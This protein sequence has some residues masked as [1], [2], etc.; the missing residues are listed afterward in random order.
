MALTVVGGRLDGARRSA[1]PV[2]MAKLTEKQEKF[3]QAVGIEGLSQSDAYRRSYAVDGMAEKTVHTSAYKLSIVPHVAA[4][5]AELRSQTAANAVGPATFDVAKLFE[6]YLEIH[7]ADP[8]DLIGIKVG[9]CRFC[10]GEGHLFQWREREYLE[11]VEK[12]ERSGGVDRAGRP[13]AMP[14]PA[15]GFGYKHFLPPHPDCP[16][17][18]GEGVER[19]VPRDSEKLSKGA[20]LLYRGAQQTK[21]GIKVMM[22]DKDKA[23]EQIGRI[24]GAF[25]DKLRVDLTGKVAS[26]KL[27]TTDPKEAAEAYAKMVDGGVK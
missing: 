13:V 20:R 7:N 15:G 21:D 8:N 10:Y 26:L 5:I 25:D 27:T 23:L 12:W 4:R 6:T 1:Y 22:A 11:A 3:A 9:A 16:E 19:V 18:G 17:C 14:D 24:L 2:V